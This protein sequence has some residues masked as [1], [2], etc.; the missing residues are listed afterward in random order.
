MTNHDTRDDTTN[1][2][3][4]YAG[5]NAFQCGFDKAMMMVQLNERI[6]NVE[7]ALN[8]FKADYTN[9]IETFWDEFLRRYTKNKN[10]K[11]E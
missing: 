1:D 10:N 5:H 4:D 3:R 11:E 2:T 6:S 8:E 9:D 7:K